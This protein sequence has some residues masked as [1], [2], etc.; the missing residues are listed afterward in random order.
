MKLTPIYKGINGIKLFY[1]TF[2]QY[3]KLTLFLGKHEDRLP[4]NPNINYLIEAQ[5]E[6][7]LSTERY[8][9]LAECILPGEFHV[10]AGHTFILRPAE[11]SAIH[12][13]PLSCKGVEAKKKFKV[14]SFAPNKQKKTTTTCQANT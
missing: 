11:H 2:I 9:S 13:T 1:Y 10:H 7:R 12:L 5:Y 6:L 8:L 4:N 3:D 14:Y